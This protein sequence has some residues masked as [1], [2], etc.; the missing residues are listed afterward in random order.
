MATTSRTKDPNQRLDEAG[1][2]IRTLEKKLK[3][4]EQQVEIAHQQIS[5]FGELVR[6]L[7]KSMQQTAQ[8]NYRHLDERIGRLEAAVK[9]LDQRKSDRRKTTNKEQTKKT[10]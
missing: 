5:G 8:G 3:A 4:A 9:D 7:S 6:N 1:R 10:S 2:Y